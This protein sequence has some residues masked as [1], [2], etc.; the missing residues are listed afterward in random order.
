M[1]ED[2]IIYVE[3]EKYLEIIGFASYVFFTKQITKY[4]G[5]AGGRI[6]T[7][8]EF[9]ENF[10]YGKIAE[11]AF[12][13]FLNRNFSLKT[14]TEVDIAGFCKGKY[15][16]DIVSLKSNSDFI[17][18][19]FWIDVKEVR[20]DQ[21]WSLVSASST[22]QRPYDAYV[23]VW[24][25]LPEEHIIWLVKNV[26]EV[27]K[28][29]SKEW[30]NEVSRIAENIEK[31]PCRIIGF[32]LWNEIDATMHKEDHALRT[33]GGFYFDGKTPLFDP[34]DSSWKG[35]KVKE[36]IGF[37]LSKLKQESKWELLA[38]LILKNK[39]IIGEVPL[40]RTKS[41]ELYKTYGLPPDFE[42]F[43]DCRNAFQTYLYYQLEEIKQKFGTVERTSSWF[44]QPL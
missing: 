24:V 33:K 13:L 14:L 25:G 29:M 7:L 31:I 12:K 39:K 5:M 26:P 38:S 42:S 3:K 1:S 11:E 40:K 32:V 15:L 43:Q 35:V 4:S 34:E 2:E 16:P 21:K 19:N 8:S 6:R 28:R 20:R 37:F 23:V 27:E 22:Q 18:L 41:G 9:W 17:P 36:N 30:L 44:A 10:I